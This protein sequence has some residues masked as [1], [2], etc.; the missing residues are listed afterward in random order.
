MPASAE[1][2][3]RGAPQTPRRANTEAGGEGQRKER[4]EREPVDLMDMMH[5]IIN[6]R[7]RSL[8]ALQFKRASAAF[9]PPRSTHGV[10]P[11]PGVDGRLGDRTHTVSGPHT[12]FCRQA[13][14]PTADLPT[15]STQEETW[16]VEECQEASAGEPPNSA[17]CPSSCTPDNHDHAHLACTRPRG[18]SRRGG[19][20]GHT[21]P[22]NDHLGVGETEAATILQ[23][24]SPSPLPVYRLNSASS[25][26]QPPEAP[27]RGSSARST[28][29]SG[30]FSSR[31]GDK[32]DSG[33]V[34]QSPD[35]VPATASAAAMGDD[36]EMVEVV[37]ATLDETRPG[38]EPTMQLELEPPDSALSEPVPLSCPRATVGATI[39]GL[40]TL[41]ADAGPCSAGCSEVALAAATTDA[42]HLDPGESQRRSVS[43]A[44][45]VSSGRGPPRRAKVDHAGIE[46][47][48]RDSHHHAELGQVASERV[49]DT[50]TP[51]SMETV[52]QGSVERIV[53]AEAMQSR[54]PNG[55]GLP[56]AVAGELGVQEM[57]A[58]QAEC[59]AQP[60]VSDGG[61]LV[62]TAPT[63]AGKSLVADVLVL[64]SLIR[65]SKLAIICLPFV[66]LYAPPRQTIEDAFG[67]TS[68]PGVALCE[69]SST[70]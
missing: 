12:V 14:P 19:G 42:V 69:A 70:A 15:P 31:D 36:Y 18:N 22:S 2:R 10:T 66:A 20:E 21:S 13:L 60:G 47:L 62:F 27:A 45:Q 34:L 3:S 58:W 23:P 56:P 1:A 35:F 38:A 5:R 37:P 17:T 68:S 32:L 26:L 9:V 54:R 30:Q 7:K 52:A 44:P 51:L 65:T 25:A 41:R 28:G 49:V 64:R 57:H 59:L 29:H 24:P 40:P 50:T 67:S 61:N 46:S 39:G 63:S 48:V 43:V 6:P 33:D 4:R 53:E 11:S 8:S 55:W 16:L